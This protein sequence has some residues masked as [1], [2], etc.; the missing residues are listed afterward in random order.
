MNFL[1]AAAGTGGHVFPALAV[2]EA[3]VDLGVDQSSVVYVGGD[4]LEKDVFPAAG[5]PF[6]GLDV[7]GLKRSLA[8]RNLRLPAVVA[9][10]SRS[11]SR[12]ISERGIGA[13]LGMGGYVTVPASLAARRARV[14]LYVAEQNAEAGLANRICSR[15]ARRAFASFPDTIGLARADWVGNPIRVPL[16]NF[17]R[18][19]L[20]PEARRHFDLPLDGTVVGVMGGSL[21]AAVLNR[22]ARLL[23]RSNPGYSILSLA[24]SAHAGALENEATHSGSNR[25]SGFKWVVRGFEPRMELFYAAVD[26]VVARAGGVVAEYLATA[27]P[28]ILIP[29]GFGSGRHQIA[30]ARALERAG[31]ALVLEETEVERAAVVVADALSRRAELSAA[32]AQLAR[33][34]AA[35]EIARAMLDGGPT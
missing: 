7:A 13:V 32:G 9:R 25:P 6:L 16:A 15:W 8:W 26:V 27:T 14:P 21:G 11:I 33:P 20:R 22:V 2:G 3:L 17:D 4:R 23:S 10:A 35:H 30:N 31:A 24:G 28:A 19:A 12:A 29:G 5:F 18:A 34:R 1:I